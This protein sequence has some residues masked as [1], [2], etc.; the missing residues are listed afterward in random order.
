M[1]SDDHIHFK[2]SENRSIATSLWRGFLGKCPN[3]NSGKQFKGYLKVVNRCGT[4]GTDLS[5]HRADDLPP[6]LT[7][8]I[9]GHLIVGLILIVERSTQLTTNQH[10][11]IWIPLTIILSLLLLQPLKGAVVGLQWALRMH[12]FEAEEEPQ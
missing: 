2:P 5:H 9:V 1:P 7:I 3:C 6:Y 11:A 10:L 4:C 8:F 12:G